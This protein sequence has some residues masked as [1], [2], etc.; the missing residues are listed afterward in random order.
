[1]AISSMQ[2]TITQLP[3]NDADNK[4]PAFAGT[5]LYSKQIMRKRDRCLMERYGSATWL[6]RV[7]LVSCEQKRSRGGKHKAPWR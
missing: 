4:T 7:T 5:T 6:A 1:M 2:S 3:C